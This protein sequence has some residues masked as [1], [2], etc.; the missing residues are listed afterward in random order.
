MVTCFSPEGQFCFY[1]RG[2]GKISGKNKGA[3]QPLSYGRFTLSKSPSGTYALSESIPLIAYIR[4]DSLDTIAC[5]NLVQEICHRLISPEETP[6]LY[7]WAIKALSAIK[8]GFS[9]LTSAAIFMAS[10]LKANGYGLDVDECVICHRKQGIAGLSYQEG[11][12]LCQD[13]L[14]EVDGQRCTARKLKIIRYLFR[15]PI[16]EFTRV[17]FE[18]AEMI[19]IITELGGYLYEMAGIRLRSLSIIDKL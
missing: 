15:V 3:V 1:G 12:F 5:D 4:D 13:D 7:P 19:E 8:D 17:E 10:V 2:I 16:E 14:L 11:G 18:K 6:N 9:P